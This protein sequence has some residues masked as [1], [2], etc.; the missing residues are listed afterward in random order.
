VTNPQPNQYILEMNEEG[1]VLHY[2]FNVVAN[3]EIQG[4][5]NINAEG[6]EMNFDFSMTH[7]G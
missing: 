5:M 7:Q 1:S 3:E 6:C 2:E 4:K